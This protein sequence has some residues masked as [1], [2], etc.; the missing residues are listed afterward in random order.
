MGWLGERMGGCRSAS[1]GSCIQTV[2][3]GYDLVTRSYL[4]GWLAWRG[5]RLSP[6]SQK[7][8]GTQTS[9]CTASYTKTDNTR[10]QQRVDRFSSCLRLCRLCACVGAMILFMWGCRLSACL[11]A[12]LPACLVVCLSV[13]PSLPPP[14]IKA[15]CLPPCVSF[16]RVPCPMTLSF[17]CVHRRLY[18]EGMMQ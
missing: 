3:A 1:W 15:P 4:P 17:L 2:P 18:T 11:P 10:P 14:S 16:H 9:S 6:A 7:R 5:H 13:P 8:A 12:C